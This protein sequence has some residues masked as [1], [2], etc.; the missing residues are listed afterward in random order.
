M[1]I[2]IPSFHFTSPEEKLT[3]EWALKAVHFSFYNTANYSLL[4]GK[5][6]E[7]IEAYSSGKFSMEPYKRMYKS[8]KRK[9]M[10]GNGEAN[11]VPG[12]RRDL[13]NER[14]DQDMQF[15][16]V[17]AI[18]S[19]LNSATALVQKIPVEVTC[20]AMDP[21][22]AEKKKEDITFLKN[23]PQLE[24]DLQDF[25]DQL[26]IGQVDLGT[27]KHSSIPFTSSP[28]GLDLNEPDELD[29][30]V[31]LLYS[32][33]VESSFEAVLQEFYKFKMAEQI[34]LLEIMD[35]FKFGVS[36]HRAFQSS[37]TH[38]PDIEY[39][40]PWDIRVPYSRLPDMS[41]RTHTFDYHYLTVMELF[42]NFS[43][44][45]GTQEQLDIMINAA[46]TGYL[47]RNGGVPGSV[48]PNNF[49]T[50]RVNCVYCEIKSV[51][52]VGVGGNKKSKKGFEYITTDPKKANDKI[53]GQNTYCFWWL[54][55]TDYIFNI[56]RLPY[57][58]RERGKEQYQGFSHNIYR[59]Q[60]RGAVE[61]CIPENKK[62]QI[63]DIKMQ[64][65]LIMSLPA[66]KYIDL[67]YLRGALGGLK[68]DNNEYTMV[69]LVEM[70]LEQNLI[71]GDTEGFDA[72][73]DGQLK[74]FMEIPGGLKSELVG[75]INAKAQAYAE[76]SKI[77]GINDQLTGQGVNPEGLVGIQKLL[78]NSSINALYYVNMAI[79][80]QYEGLFNVWASI[81]QAAIAE[82]GKTK[83][84]IIDLIGS[85]K[86]EIIQGLDQVPLHTIGVTVSI[87][88]REEE[89]AR[90]EANLQRLKEMGAIDITGEYMLS[91]ISNP[92]DKMALLAVREKL[93]QRRKTAEQRAQYEAAQKLEQQRGQNQMAVQQQKGQQEKEVVYAKGDVQ[94]K[95]IEL[96]SQLGINA[97]QMEGII[98]KSLQK[99]RNDA[100]LDKSISTLNVKNNLE[101]A[102]P[103]Q[104]TG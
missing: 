99:D 96:A 65:A 71:L 54:I 90:V 61:L 64:H 62:I 32:L 95:I 31:N 77:T 92:K 5:D 83:Q 102:E 40:Y 91:S 38:L 63:A 67:K 28:Y 2:F 37:I 35:Q 58:N 4:E 45:I 84:G 51:D 44:E 34:K 89:R 47:A 41:D 7:E 14:L 82:G 103:L 81:I 49:N 27:T 12:Q 25:A 66:G 85:K 60:E 68:D 88:Q 74:P 57:A 1:S 10:R 80:H 3:K 18:P 72:K 36:C 46:D 48:P 73:I 75:Y 13:L 33:M 59:S 86:V 87:S 29:V 15:L 6:V 9:S 98:K 11:P 39:R 79:E 19:K 43:N 26:G 76:I 8:Q 56:H 21:L 52:W 24:A 23:K 22:A 97:A 55:G 69:R 53:W 16:P 78:I 104:Q 100:Q 94:A 70:A 30:F 93:F 101:Q 17:A 50:F 20:T 42:N